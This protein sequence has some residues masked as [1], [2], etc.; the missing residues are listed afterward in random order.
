MPPNADH[1]G[2]QAA[3]QPQAKKQK[4]PRHG[5]EKQAVEAAAVTDGDPVAPTDLLDLAFGDLRASVDVLAEEVVPKLTEILDILRAQKVVAQTGMQEFTE[6]ARK[7]LAAQVAVNAQATT[8]VEVLRQFASIFASADALT[9][10]RFRRVMQHVER[11]AVKAAASDTHPVASM[12][13]SYRA[14]LAALAIAAVM[15]VAYILG[16]PP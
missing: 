10:K 16:A 15:A 1:A 12:T 14:I 13:I 9:R 3:P 4:K 8:Q 6:V 7:L 2:A 11:A 5:D